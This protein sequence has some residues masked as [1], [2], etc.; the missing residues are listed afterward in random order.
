[1]VSVGERER[2]SH[3]IFSPRA[4][5][6]KIIIHSKIS[7]KPQ[8]RDAWRANFSQLYSLQKPPTFGPDHSGRFPKYKLNP[9]AVGRYSG[10]G[11]GNGPGFSGLGRITGVFPGQ[12]NP[13]FWAGSPGPLRSPA[14]GFFRGHF[15]ANKFRNI[16]NVKL[17][18]LALIFNSSFDHKYLPSL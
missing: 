17:K 5:S 8:L 2:A 6:R 10:A 16:I 7:S 4:I 9:Q 14:L 3:S 12:K 13:N 1:M 15:P 18:Y 11:L